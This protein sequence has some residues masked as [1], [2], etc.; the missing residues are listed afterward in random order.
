MRKFI[1][2]IIASAAMLTSCKKEKVASSELDLMRDSVFYYEKQLY[3]WNDAIPEYATFQP[4]RYTG[5]NDLDALNK[6]LFALSQY[7]I[8]PATGKAYEYYAADPTHP[9]YSFIDDGSISQELNGVTG[10]FGFAPIWNDLDDL[11]IRYVAPNSPAATAGIK[12]GYQITKINNR[13]NLTYDGDGGG[14]ANLNFVINAY[15]NSTTIS[16]TLKRPDASTF[17]VTLNTA[18]Y[19]IN[20]VYNY[21][22][23]TQGGKKVGYFVFNEFTS[24]DNSKANINQAFNEFAAQGITELVVDLRYNGGGRVETSEYLANVIAPA[25]KV[26]SKMYTTYYNSLMQSGKA[27]DLLRKQTRKD[28]ETGKSY[29]YADFDY[30]EERNISMFSREDVSVPALALNHVF[31]IVTGSTASASEL[32]IN[33]LK[34]V[35]DV[36]LIGTTT[37]G[38]PVGFSYLQINKY[39]MYTPMFETKNSVN[40]GGYFTGMLPASPDYPG[41]KDF[42]DVTHDFGDPTETLLAHALKFVETGTYTINTPQIQSTQRQ[43]TMTIDQAREAAIQLD[44]PKFR[45]MVLSRPAFKK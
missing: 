42:D 3:Y 43:R 29:T 38:K 18:T 35:M 34:P 33:N 12:R 44:A 21:K 27:D 45:S 8:N 16:M 32:L 26:G 19:T 30:S 6:E 24:L 4:R 40:Q 36:K 9:K 28:E 25:A 17:D 23:I 5:S 14:G 2:L 31:F 11:R 22:V 41:F 1:Y 15:A 39:Q 10:D 20:P 13:T 7:K 37:Y